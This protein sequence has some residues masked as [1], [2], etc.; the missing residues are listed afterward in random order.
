M[1]RDS[2]IPEIGN[3][4]PD[5]SLLRV[6]QI[7]ER[8]RVSRSHWYAGVKDGKYPPGFLL[9]KRIHVWR[10]RDIKAIINSEAAQ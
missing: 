10:G 5:D 2:K 9:S 6:A 4:I 1:S 7:V 8:I 3:N